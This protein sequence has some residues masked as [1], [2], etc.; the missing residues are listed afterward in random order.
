MDA[1]QGVEALDAVV[2]RDAGAGQPLEELPV[3]G[4]ARVGL[5]GAGGVAVDGQVPAG[6]DLGV[7]LAQRPGG[8]VAGVGEEALAGLALAAVELGERFQ[9][10]E[11][12]APDLDDLGRRGQ[13]QAPGHR[14]HGEDVGGDVF[15]G[16]PVA[17]GGRPDEPAPL[18][19]QRDGQ[20]VELRLADE[21]HRL[22]DQPLQALAPGGE[23][24]EVEG[25]VERQHRHQVGHRAERDRTAGPLRRRVLGDELGMLGLEL[26]E[27]PDEGVVLGVGDLRLVEL[28]VAPV[29][30]PDQLPEFVDADA[31]IEVV[32]FHGDDVTV[33]ASGARPG[34][35]S[36]T[37][38]RRR[39]GCC[40]CSRRRPARCGSSCRSRRSPGRARCRGR[41]PGSRGSAGPT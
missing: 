36:R 37:P 13:L 39:P 24:V 33:G 5:E 34:W 7:Q 8:G 28:V 40:R 10:H 35:R 1:G 25:V 9:R 32:A 41:R 3:G 17:P 14:L 19:D 20:A 22:G 18:V 29:V 6:G 21:G 15:T 23:I 11:D 38:A 4:D 27:A 12:L 2:D 16:H 31:D 26:E 30:V